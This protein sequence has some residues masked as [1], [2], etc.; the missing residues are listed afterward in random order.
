MAGAAVLA[1]AVPGATKPTRASAA[2]SAGMAIQALSRM[3]T[4]FLMGCASTQRAGKRA[5]PRG[6]AP[7]NLKI[8]LYHKL[9]L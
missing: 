7:G 5:H 4:P 1:R 2:E 8:K 6:A 9:Y 3:V